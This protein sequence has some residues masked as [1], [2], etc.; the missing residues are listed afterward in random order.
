MNNEL[1]PEFIRQIS[2]Q[3]QFGYSSQTHCDCLG[4]VVLL[5]RSQ[6][7]ECSWEPKIIRYYTKYDEVLEQLAENKFFLVPEVEQIV[8]PVTALIKTRGE[9][10]HLGVYYP[11]DKLIYSVTQ[12]GMVVQNYK[13]EELFYYQG[14]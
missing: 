11:D 13:D 14:T 3:F 7:K 9:R 10:G 8:F 1:F 2:P 6:G 5:L 4:L 12:S